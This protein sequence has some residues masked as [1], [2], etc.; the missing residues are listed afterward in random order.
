MNMLNKVVNQLRKTRIQLLLAVIFI[1]SIAFAGIALAQS[2]N[3]LDITDYQKAQSDPTYSQEDF[4][5]GNGKNIVYFF[6]TLVSGCKPGAICGGVIQSSAI[7]QSANAVAMLYTPP[8]SGVEYMASVLQNMGVVQPAYAQTGTGF[9]ALSPLLKL[10]RAMRDFTYVFFVILFVGMGLAVMFRMRLSPQTVVTIQSALPRLVV[11]LVLVTFSYAI[12]G[13]MI[14]FMYILISLGALVLGG[15]GLTNTN[16]VAQFQNDFTNGGFLGALKPLFDLLPSSKGAAVGGGNS[17]IDNSLNNAASTNPFMGMM[18]SGMKIGLAIGGASKESVGGTIGKEFLGST[19][20]HL[21]LSLVVLWMIFR[22][23]FQLLQSYIS[24]ILLVIF[25]PI[26]IALG[27]IPGF[28]SFGGWI[29]SLMANLMV[30]VAVAFIL[31]IGHLLAQPETI[32]GSLWKPPLLLGNGL[33]GDTIAPILAI[34]ILLIVHQVPAAVKAAFGVK[35]LGI[36]NPGEAWGSTVGPFGSAG[37][38]GGI[39]YGMQRYVEG[40]AIA[41]A[42]VDASGNPIMPT[43]GWRVGVSRVGR[44]LSR[45]GRSPF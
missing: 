5:F 42:G 35:G 7:D 21:I 33:V 23:F 19:L 38:T 6:D 15:A 13:L 30:F 1:F 3:D 32:A 17:I 9:T 11:A 20:V 26:Q 41:A 2:A 29:K 12:A 34:G 39:E 44:T 14:D 43:S 37:R 10:W 45:V 31:M 27:V 25:S 22:L 40:P 4:V 16:L 36:F 24:I 8:A 28:P 18:I